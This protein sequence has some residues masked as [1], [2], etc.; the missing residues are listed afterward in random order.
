MF[1]NPEIRS[2]I[3]GY[4]DVLV[5]LYYETDPAKGEQSE[6]YKLETARQAIEKFWYLFGR[7]GLWAQCHITGYCVARDNPVAVDILNDEFKTEITKDSHLL[8]VLGLL[9]IFNPV[10]REDILLKQ[11]EDRF[12]N[13]AGI[14]SDAAM[15][16]I[17]N[18]LLM[19]RCANS[20]YWRFDLQSALRSLNE[21]E[22][23][24]LLNPSKLRLRGKP[25]TLNSWK[26]EALRQVHFRVGTGSHHFFGVAT[27][28]ILHT[29]SASFQFI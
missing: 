22:V 11:M 7:L 27:A 26:L 19:S 10:D 16:N 17:I 1:R 12:E 2:E 6:F 9:Y 21:G 20:S 23:E 8:E 25:A 29:P 3:S 24:P 18:E 14:M 4:I 28:P 5:E 15:R 13:E